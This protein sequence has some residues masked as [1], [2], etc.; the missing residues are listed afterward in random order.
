MTDLTPPITA[1]LSALIARLGSDHEG[2]QMA[3]LANIRRLLADRGLSFTDLAGLLTEPAPVSPLR[4]ADDWV[5][6]TWHQLAPWVVEN[7]MGRLQPHEREFAMSMVR[8]LVL[9]GEPS[10]KHGDWLR[11]LYTRLGGEE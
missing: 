1:R 9:R 11:G 3:C 6:Q 7:D 2:E 5:P 10:A 8:R 4:A